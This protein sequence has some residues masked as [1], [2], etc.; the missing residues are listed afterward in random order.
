MVSSLLLSM[1]V[2]ACL[3]LLRATTLFA[4]RVVRIGIARDLTRDVSERLQGTPCAIV[5]GSESRGRTDASWTA[6]TTGA[7]AE[8]QV[9]VEFPRHPFGADTL[10]PVSARAAGWCS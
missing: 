2:A 8:M 10:L 9:H 7:F 1:A 5:A 6:S 3:S 4:D